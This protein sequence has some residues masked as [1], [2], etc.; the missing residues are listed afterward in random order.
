MA[1]AFSE[2]QNR[3]IEEQAKASL[4]GTWSTYAEDEKTRKA[5]QKVIDNMD[6]IDETYYSAD[7]FNKDNPDYKYNLNA[8]PELE[9]S[10]GTDIKKDNLD[11]V[12]KGLGF[13]TTD[14]KADWNAVAETLGL[15]YDNTLDGVK[16]LYS[17]DDKNNK[18]YFDVSNHGTVDTF[19]AWN[20]LMANPGE[21][22]LGKSK[23]IDAGFLAYKIATN[24]RGKDI[25]E[26]FSTLLN[27]NI[28]EILYGNSSWGNPY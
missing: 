27:G 11:E 15:R 6:R 19:T 7:A 20:E 4:A 12:V 14:E 3:S 13:V 26:D 23:N 28:D 1:L 8:H 17:L 10:D 25:A 18:Q 5:G 9:F 22:G 24:S 21:G 2:E 16:G